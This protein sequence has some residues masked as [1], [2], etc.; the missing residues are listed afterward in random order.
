MKPSKIAHGLCNQNADE[1]VR[2]ICPPWSDGKAV[3]VAW[4]HVGMLKRQRDELMSI[5][6]HRDYEIKR[7]FQ[8]ALNETAKELNRKLSP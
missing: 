8:D 4:S 6:P 7:Q 3:R 5:W 2:M 1:C